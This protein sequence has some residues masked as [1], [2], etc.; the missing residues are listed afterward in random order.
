M[1]SSDLIVLLTKNDLYTK[2]KNCG[3]M[4]HKCDTASFHIIVIFL[5]VYVSVE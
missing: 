1:Y 5:S 3:K 4:K 2:R